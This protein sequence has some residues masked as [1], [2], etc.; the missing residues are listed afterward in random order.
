MPKQTIMSKISDEEF[1]Q[2]V[3][4]SQTYKEIATRCGYSN[5]SGASNSIVKKRI[6]ELG[7]DFKSSKPESII[8]EDKDIFVEDS[9][10]DQ[11]T[12]RRRYFTEKYSE[13]K[14]AICGQGPFWNG[15]ELTLTLDHINGHNHDDRLENLRWVC[16]NCDRQLDTFAGRNITIDPKEKN[17]CID[18][19]AEILQSST[20]CPIC[21]NK[22]KGLN[23]RKV[24]RPSREDLKA[25]IRVKPFLQIGKDYGVTDNAVRKWCDE[26]NLPRKKKDITR[27]KD[28]D[29]ENL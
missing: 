22:A 29:W 24:E 4:S 2:I 10:V 28:I 16:P 21:A 8:R 6:E 12:L 25:L 13:Y 9:P 18:C 3:Q 11:S 27:I 15:K 26:Y 20:R 5:F 19:G 23:A 17:H 7:L 1:L 14:C